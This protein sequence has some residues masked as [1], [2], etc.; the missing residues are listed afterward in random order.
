MI[1]VLLGLDGSDVSWD[2]S[3]RLREMPRHTTLLTSEDDS[4]FVR[5]LARGLAVLETFDVQHQQMT[6]TEVAQ[7]VNM[8]RGSTRRLLL[9]L[10]YLGYV[11]ITEGNYYLRPRV[12]NLGLG[13]LS[14]LPVWSAARSVIS[15]VASDTGE[16]CSVAILEDVEIVYVARVAA[17]RIINDYIAVGTRFPAYAASMGKVL[18]AALPT[19]ELERR[20]FHTPLSQITTKTHTDVNKLRLEL[21]ETA[22]RGWATNDEELEV[23]LCS[24]A[25]GIKDPSGHT[26]AAINVSAPAARVSRELLI[27]YLPTLRDASQAISTLIAVQ[28]NVTAVASP[29]TGS[30]RSI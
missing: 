18:L 16:S 30:K 28:G 2:I 21:R 22:R 6:L 12:V 10:E 4:D 23:G 20:I 1:P 11:G 14:S 17:R 13:F 26:V 24:I 25:V 15:E 9:T 5:A 8:T 27:N 7:R 29:F 3:E 19:T